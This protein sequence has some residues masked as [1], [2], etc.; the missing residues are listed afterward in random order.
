MINKT[1]NKI[2]NQTTVG[3]WPCVRPPKSQSTTTTYIQPNPSIRPLRKEYPNNTGITLIALVITIIVLLI[4]AGVTLSLVMGNDGIL[5][6]AESAVNQTDIAGGHEQAELLAS[7]HVTDYYDKKY[8]NNDS[9]VSEKSVADY[10]AEKLKDGEDSGDYNVKATGRKIEVSKNGTTITT[11]TIKDDGKIDWGKRWEYGTDEEGN[12][13]ITD[14]TQT[15]KIGDYVNYD[16][17]DGATTTSVTSYGTDNGYGDQKFNLSSY[18]YG[19]RVLGVDE[20]TGGILLIAE[21]FIGPDEGGYVNTT[22]NRTYYYLQG[23]AGYA[24]GI[25]ELKKN[26]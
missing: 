23:K 16:P 19:W 6:R 24:N 4:L 12:T 25:D 14:G 20:N 1:K 18:D 10:V 3:A 26:L 5:G 15:L 8:V 21:E 11:G 9:D 2:K 13:T 17:K 22:Y 7:S